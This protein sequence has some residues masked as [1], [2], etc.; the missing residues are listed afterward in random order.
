MGAVLLQTGSKCHFPA[1]SLQNMIICLWDA[2][3][4]CK[5]SHVKGPF[6]HMIVEGASPLESQ[7]WILNPF[8]QVYHHQSYIE[9]QLHVFYFTNILAY[10]NFI[11]F[12]EFEPG[13]FYMTLRGIIVLHMF[14]F[15]TVKSLKLN[16]VGF[17]W[18]TKKCVKMA[19]SYWNL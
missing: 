14:S 2:A 5:C 16:S 10:Y 3:N 18:H 8:F 6:S 9:D 4:H 7:I 19:S 17:V 12:S 15:Q 1:K 13:H 11:T